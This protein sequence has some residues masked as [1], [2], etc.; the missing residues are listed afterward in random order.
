M[1]KTIVK[2][3]PSGYGSSQGGI[4][5]PV[6]FDPLNNQV[7]LNYGKQQLSGTGVIADVL[8]SMAGVAGGLGA[9]YL[10]G[11]NPYIIA[12]GS[13]MAGNSVKGVAE[14]LGLGHK[15]K[16][17]K[18]SGVIPQYFIDFVDRLIYNKK[19]FNYIKDAI[20]KFELSPQLKTRLARAASELISG[21][22][23]SGVKRV[24][25]KRAL[26][27]RGGV[28]QPNTSNYGMVKF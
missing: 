26:T 20:S 19:T 14:M 12:G 13:T 9:A 25:K 8:G 4:M 21:M 2:N 10:S 18:G 17:M 1:K 3:K 23:G 5:V 24:G 16:P 11:G 28:F 27:G 7:S 6:G 15:S 22:S